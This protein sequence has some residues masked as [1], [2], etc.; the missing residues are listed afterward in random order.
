MEDL[1]LDLPLRPTIEPTEGSPKLQLPSLAFK[2]HGKYLSNRFYKEAVL[3]ETQKEALKSVVEWF[4][5][6]ETKDY[7]AVVSM[8]TGTG[9]TAVICC[10][11]YCLGGAADTISCIDFTKP[12]LVIA[13]GLSILDQLKESLDDD[14]FL[15]RPHINLIKHTVDALCVL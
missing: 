14:P 5:D 6:A 9:K 7:T 2:R 3:Y 1:P 10:L 13:P 4:S 11:P 15:M 8:P 12:I